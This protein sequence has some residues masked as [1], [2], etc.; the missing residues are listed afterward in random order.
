[1]PWVGLEDIPS[2]FVGKKFLSSTC[3][4][5]EFMNFYDNQ[6]LTQ[7][8]DDLTNYK[9]KICYI[10]GLS[11]ERIDFELLNKVLSASKEAVFLMGVKSDG[12]KETEKAKQKLLQNHTNIRIWEDLNYQELAELVFK[13]DIGIIPYKVSGQ[14]LRIC[15]NKFFEYSALKK[16]TISTSIPSMSRFS[17][18]ARIASNHQDF[19]TLIKEELNHSINDISKNN[20]KKISEQ[21][22]AIK[23]LMR[24]ANILVNN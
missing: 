21:A 11:W 15:P 24:I 18:P 10:G 7:R 5:N 13:S 17:P 20:L 22:S 2:N 23:S 16:R 12:L 3:A 6:L 19:I 8:F 14:N 9:N 1:M 4:G